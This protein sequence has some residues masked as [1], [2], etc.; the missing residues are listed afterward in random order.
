MNLHV[1]PHNFEKNLE[2]S[3]FS[4]PSSQPAYNF[5]PFL[6]QGQI[7][8]LASFLLEQV[9]IFSLCSRGEESVGCVYVT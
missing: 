1:Q 5:L 4:L 6:P 9:F 3:Y 2:W 7:S 8:S